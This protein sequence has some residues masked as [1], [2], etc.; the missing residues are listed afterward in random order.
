MKI[1]INQDSLA[2]LLFVVFGVAGLVFGQGYRVGTAMQMGPG[3]LPHLLS[4]LLIV[5]G[6]A[7]CVRGVVMK[8]E[9]LTAWSF[10]PLIFVLL[11]FLAFAAL[12]ERTGLPAAALACVLVGALGG[13]DFRWREQV[14]LSIGMA[15]AS[16]ALFIYGLSLPMHLWPT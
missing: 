7:T 8:G 4:W 3:Y 5:F 15:I 6:I 13:T 14:I 9:K 11:S 1:S 12:I 2:G 10:R 16:S